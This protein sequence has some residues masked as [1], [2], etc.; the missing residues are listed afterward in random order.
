MTACGFP[1]NELMLSFILKNEQKF[2]MQTKGIPHRGSLKICT[3]IWEHD[4][5]CCA[6]K[7]VGSSILP[8]CVMG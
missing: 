5:A 1:K 3:K 7:T 8:R 4:T 6:Q 2:S